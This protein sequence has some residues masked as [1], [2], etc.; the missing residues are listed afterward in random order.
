VFRKIRDR[1]KVYIIEGAYTF[2]VI[3]TIDFNA[4]CFGAFLDFFEKY[5]FYFA[6]NGDSLFGVFF[7]VIIAADIEFGFFAF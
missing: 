7:I 3:K 5:I 2:G 4:L 6:D 1:D